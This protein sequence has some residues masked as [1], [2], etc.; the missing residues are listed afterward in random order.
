[1]NNF[2]WLSI[3]FFNDLK[4]VLSWVLI[5]RETLKHFEFG[6]NSDARCTR[7]AARLRPAVA[8]RTCRAQRLA[9]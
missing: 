6:F 7:F 1:M 2:F 5:L 9:H 3:H 4:Q 8:T